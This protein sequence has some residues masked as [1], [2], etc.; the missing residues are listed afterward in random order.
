[1]AFRAMNLLFGLVLMTGFSWGLY[2]QESIQTKAQYD[3][4]VAAAKAAARARV[5]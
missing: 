3:E 5:T 4:D 2:G 1:M